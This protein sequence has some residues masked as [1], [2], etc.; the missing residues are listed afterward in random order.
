M[1]RCA[2]GPA[3]TTPPRHPREGRLDRSRHGHPRCGHTFPPSQTS[4]GS[5]SIRELSEHLRAETPAQSAV[6]V[7]ASQ[8][9]RG[10]PRTGDASVPSAPPGTAPGRPARLLLSPPAPPS[11]PPGSPLPLCS[12]P[13]F[14]LL[15]LIGEG[16]LKVGYL[17][18]PLIVSQIPP[19]Q[20]HQPE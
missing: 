10:R 18:L 9:A 15:N 8:P 7:P 5:A 17:R 19:G 14:Q 20:K 1:E 13:I 4:S 3:R 2:A 12:Q 11:L 16:Q 6:V